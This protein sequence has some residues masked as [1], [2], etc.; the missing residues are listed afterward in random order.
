MLQDMD[1]IEASCIIYVK[2]SMF[3][4]LEQSKT[5]LLT[6]NKLGIVRLTVQ[7]V[8]IVSVRFMYYLGDYFRQSSADI[9]SLKQCSMY[10]LQPRDFGCCTLL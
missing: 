7:H 8:L 1:N 9:L 2:V 4:H 10:S 6:F 5:S 3:I